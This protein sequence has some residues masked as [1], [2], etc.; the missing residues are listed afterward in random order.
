MIRQTVTLDKNTQ[1]QLTSR[2]PTN[3]KGIYDA[4]GNMS[5]WVDDQHDTFSNHRASFGWNHTK[6]HGYLTP[7]PYWLGTAG[8][9]IRPVFD[10]LNKSLSDETYV[11]RVNELVS[12][13]SEVNH[14]DIY[15]ARKEIGSQLHNL[16]V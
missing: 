5:I 13:L 2:I 11:T 15:L 12:Y 7:R 6:D 9:G 4:V 8:L 1:T 16:L 14:S 10:K 3:E